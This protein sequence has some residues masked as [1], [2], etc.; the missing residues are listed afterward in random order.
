M[1]SNSG[2]QWMPKYPV[3]K[4][5]ALGKWFLEAPSLMAP[6]LFLALGFNES[7]DSQVANYP[8]SN[9]DGAVEEISKNMMA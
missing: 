8:S 2:F 9:L 1:L 7:S 4:A 3:L 6:R 5:K